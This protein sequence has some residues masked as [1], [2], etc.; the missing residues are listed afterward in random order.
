MKNKTMKEKGTI[1]V[2]QLII[3]LR[4]KL[5]CCQCVSCEYEHEDDTVYKLL[6]KAAEA[7]ECMHDRIC[8][9]RA[10]HAGDDQLIGSNDIKVFEWYETLDGTIP[11]EIQREFVEQHCRRKYGDALVDAG[12]VGI[13]PPL[14]PCAGPDKRWGTKLKVIMPMY[15]NESLFEMAK[16]ASSWE[17]DDYDQKKHSGL[18]EE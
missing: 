5:N 15:S 12:C 10:A 2:R 8:V 4:E 6:T 3:D 16:K 18:M 1:D 13:H 9:I 7:L 17:A 14:L 11:L